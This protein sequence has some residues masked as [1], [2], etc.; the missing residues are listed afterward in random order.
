M[1]GLKDNSQDS[2]LMHAQFYLRGFK[3]WYLN[4]GG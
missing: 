1:K 4:K 2:Y 3:F